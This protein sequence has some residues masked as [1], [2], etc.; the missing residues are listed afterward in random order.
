MGR[1]QPRGGCPEAH[2]SSAPLTP[3][4]RSTWGGR[5]N[6]GSWLSKTLGQLGEDYRALVT[7][8]GLCQPR[9][10]TE[11]EEWAAV[12][13]CSPWG[14]RRQGSAGGACFVVLS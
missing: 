2:P 12:G 4:S 9:Q 10:P 6:Y 8:A 1:K 13:N 11:L 5:Q 14:W 7:N 3:A